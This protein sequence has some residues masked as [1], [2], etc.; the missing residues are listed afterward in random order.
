MQRVGVLST[1]LAVEFSPIEHSLGLHIKCRATGSNLSRTPGLARRAWRRC[2]FELTIARIRLEASVF[3]GSMNNNR[4]RLAVVAVALLG[5]GG[6]RAAD[7]ADRLQ[8]R[9]ACGADAGRHQQARHRRPRSAAPVRP[10]SAA[11]RRADVPRHGA[12]RRSSARHRA[13]AHRHLHVEGFLPR[14]RALERQALF[15]LQ[16][17]RGA[18]GRMGRQP[19]RH[20]R[21]QAA[22]L[23]RVGLLRSR[24]LRAKPS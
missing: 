7:G 16:Q 9:R 4:M 18:R 13:A 3:G 19:Q 17:L 23:G 22:G 2:R 6:E 8:E 15:P 20:D 12:Q 14:P 1:R 10:P 11:G 24:L 21:R 5:S